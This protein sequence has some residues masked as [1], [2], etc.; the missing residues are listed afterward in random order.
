MKRY[1]QI[2]V[3][4][5]FIGLVI[6]SGYLAAFA[7][8]SVF[9][10]GNVLAHLVA[11]VVLFLAL[12]LAATHRRAIFGG[13]KIALLFYTAALGAGLVLVVRGNLLENRNIL[14]AHIAAA[15]LSVVAL[16]PFVWKRAADHGGGWVQ[17]KKAFQVALAVLILL[18]LSAA[19]YRKAFPNAKDRIK[20]PLVVPTSMQEE[21]GGPRTPFFPSS[22][23][24]NVGGI[25]PS[26]FFM[27]SEACA[28]CH[29]QAYDEWKGSSHHFGSFNNQFYRKAIE[30][31]QDTQ[32]SP[33]G[34]KWCAGCHDHAVFFNGRFEKPIKEQIDTPEARAGL[35]CTSCH[36]ISSV[37]SS[38]GNAGFTMEYPALHELMSSKNRYIRAMNHFMVN[39]NPEP[40]RRT[41]MKPFMRQD[42]SEFCSSCHK[43]HLDI[44]VNNYR[45]FRGFNDYDNWQASGVSGQGARS[46]YYPPKT[47]TCAE[48]HMPQ[49]D[50]REPGHHD[51]KIHS[52]RFA[53]ANTALPYVNKDATQMA[54][55]TKFLTSGFIT[56][57]IFSAT[58]V[59]EKNGGQTRMIR[60]AA[61]GP[62]LMSGIA[63]GE[64]SDQAGDVFIREVGK[65]AAPL[66][67]SDLKLV[68]GT[69]A[70]IDVV[71]RT[72]KIGHFFPGG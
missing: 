18:P 36:A 29:K 12:L 69:T 58:P 33:Q 35:A 72:R 49:E 16:I 71:T 28:D 32:G 24:T 31:M 30:Y 7:T 67:K 55:T 38:M 59:D 22:S 45:W 4:A 40:H 56:M 17:F 25:I 21:G 57:D 20:N 14:L 27:D 66:D 6:N 53:A 60:R 68:P 65:V 26:N 62:Q 44:P 43:V 70:R 37:D 1:L 52:H 63:A 64:E 51:G 8:P 2:G 10:M 54:E 42:T 23:Q 3:P 46:F 41:F 39:L 47:A 19:G 15:L 13:A 5:L 61:T 48:C 11:G 50:S 34:S 9:Y